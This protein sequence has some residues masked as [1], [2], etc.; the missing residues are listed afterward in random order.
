M[1]KQNQKPKTKKT[2]KYNKKRN[3]KNK[4]KQKTKTKITRPNSLPLLPPLGCAVLFF[5][6]G[7]WFFGF[8]FSSSLLVFFCNG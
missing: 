1:A 6:G 3:Q 4:K 2:K 7:S 8:L 5:W